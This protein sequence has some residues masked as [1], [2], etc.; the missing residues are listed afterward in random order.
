MGVRCEP[1]YQTNLRFVTGLAATTSYMNRRAV[2][3]LGDVA[4]VVL[5]VLLGWILL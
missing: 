5:L 4:A 1:R 2:S 3:L